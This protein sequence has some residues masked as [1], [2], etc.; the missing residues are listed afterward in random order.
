ML[1][2]YVSYSL[3]FFYAVLC[4]VCLYEQRWSMCGYWFGAL[5]L[6]ISVI[7]MAY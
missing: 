6:N 2:L 7:R 1:S 3:L 4:V 5:V